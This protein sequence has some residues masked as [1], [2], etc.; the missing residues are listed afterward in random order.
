MFHQPAKAEHFPVAMLVLPLG[1]GC[2]WQEKCVIVTVIGTSVGCSSP[3][4]ANK[5]RLR[6][7][8]CIRRSIS[9]GQK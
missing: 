8:T 7:E 6:R 5:R 2:F 1:H 3:S 4:L 9:V